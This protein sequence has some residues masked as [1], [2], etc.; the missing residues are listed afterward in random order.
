[1]AVLSTFKT[2]LPDPTDGPYRWNAG[3]DLQTPIIV[4]YSFMV[5][6]DLPKPGSYGYNAK[7]YSVFTEAQEANFRDAAVMYETAAGIVFVEVESDAMIDIHNAHGSRYGGW[8]SLPYVN[9]YY[10]SEGV[11]VVDGRG[12]YDEGS[13]GFYTLLHELGHAV[14]MLHPHDGPNILRED[15]DIPANSVMSYNFG[16]GPTYAEELGRFDLQALDHLYGG[17][18]DVSGWRF[19][20]QADVFVISASNRDDSIYGVEGRNIIHA[21]GGN[22]AVW[23]RENHD[24]IHGG[25][26]HDSI[27]SGAG[28][29]TVTGGSGNDRLFGGHGNDELMGGRGNDILTGDDAI[30]GSDVLKG[31]RGDDILIGGR[32]NDRLQGGKGD[33]RLDGGIGD[34]ILIGGDG[35]DILTG[36]AG[37]DI[38]FL[39]S[40][41]GVEADTITDFEIG[42]DKIDISGQGFAARNLS[43]D[44][45]SKGATTT[46]SLD[47]GKSQIQLI[48]QDISHLEISADQFL[49]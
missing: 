35:N 33:D 22:D 23:G 10:T 40:Y 1:M 47:T 21:E 44:A 20:D 39:K 9:D 16:R 41:A 46:V 26:G 38:F 8:A 42:V 32:G 15:L 29:D 43:I 4:S 45:G 24:V 14:G 17:P 6:A 34:D 7:R 11:L 28:N 13:F 36:G 30:G 27:R 31:N 5:A 37:A 18:M 48:L 2:I 25:D 12:N 49:F 3:A 19:E